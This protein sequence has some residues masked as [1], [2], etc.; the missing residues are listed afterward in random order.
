MNI[1]IHQPNL[2]PWLGFFDK[3]ACADLFIFL[4]QVQFT[5]R[6]YQNRVK[7]KG[8]NGVQWLTVPVK[9]KGRYEQLTLDVEIDREHPWK[10]EHL[11]TFETIYRG[12]PGFSELMPQVEQLYERDCQRLVDMNI[13]GI[14]LIRKRLGI[15]TPLLSASEMPAAGSR[16]HLLCELVLAAGGTTY[17]SGPSGRA[18]LDESVFREKGVKLEYHQFEIA[19]YPQRF[20]EF[21]GG[22]SA[23]DYLFH[24]P[25][26]THWK[27]WRP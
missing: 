1:A 3:M 14:E 27:R 10:K 2:F 25:L 18:Y 8:P 20:G 11:K 22:L 19:E 24:D 9:S 21:T 13:P 7:L 17:L 16:S 12:T 6:G 26:L 23:L 5:K 4:D 15:E